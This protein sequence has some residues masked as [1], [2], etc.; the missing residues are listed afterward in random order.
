[1]LKKILKIIPLA[2]H[3]KYNIPIIALNLILNYYGN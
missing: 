1:M 3:I 2:L